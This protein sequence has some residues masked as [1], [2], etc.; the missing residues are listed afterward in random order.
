MP[1]RTRLAKASRTATALLLFGTLVSGSAGTNADPA[2]ELEATAVE[3]ANDTDEPVAESSANPLA[4]TRWQL[5]EFQ[6]MSDEIGTIRPEDPSRYTMQL[7]ADGSVNMRLDCNRASG[8]WSANASP[9]SAGDRF[10]FSGQFE[11]GPLAT[12]NAACPPPNLDEQFA[13]QA[14]FIRSYVIEDGRLYLSL[15]ADGGIYAW[16][17]VADE[18][19][20]QTEPDPELEEAIRRESPDYT[21][22]LVEVGGGTGK[23]RYLYGRADLNE[24][25]TDE[26]FV[27]LLG[28][29]FCGTGGCDLLLFSDTD[30]GYTLIDR[31]ATSRLPVIVSADRSAG[32]HDLMRLESGGGMP[33]SYVRHEFDGDRYVEKERLPVDPEPDGTRYL[34]GE[35]V[36][37]D[38]IP[39]EPRD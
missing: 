31:F 24:D 35:F 21:R 27:Y 11:F 39:L 20:F 1:S 5:V 6:S 16:E 28:S 4:G 29:I 33:A 7:N 26:V 10:E 22:E 17:P 23:A 30:S 13:R 14:Q 36:F 15:V 32:W 19:G 34:G 8:T 37:A 2:I 38:G 25:G 12:T 9:G 18:V 3:V